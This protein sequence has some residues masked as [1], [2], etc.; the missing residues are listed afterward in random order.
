SA[1][2]IMIK[3]IHTHKKQVKNIIV[4]IHGFIGSEETWVKKDGKRPLIDFLL[5]NSQIKKDF[6]VAL[7]E[8][9][10]KLLEY[11]PKIAR[12]ALSFIKKEKASKNL[13]IGELSKILSTEL[14]Y[15]CSEYENIILV[16]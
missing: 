7:Y 1:K 4:F 10:T 12:T 9:H 16:G 3:I 13:K 2:N 11:F 6:D 14:K 8:Y 15:K 5:K